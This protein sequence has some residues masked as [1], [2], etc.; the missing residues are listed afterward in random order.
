VHRPVA[1]TAIA[2]TLAAY[3]GIKAPSGAHGDVLEE[4]LG[5]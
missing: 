1:P 3:L 2:S 5:D 4:V